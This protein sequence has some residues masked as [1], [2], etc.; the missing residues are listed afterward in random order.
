MTER[1]VFE[2]RMELPARKALDAEAVAWS[3]ARHVQ[4][5]LLSAQLFALRT[6]NELDLT[7]EQERQFALEEVPQWTSP[8]V[9]ARIQ[10]MLGVR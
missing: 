9:R 8:E 1:D 4:R 6:A 10:A 5:V 7:P 2:I 3:S